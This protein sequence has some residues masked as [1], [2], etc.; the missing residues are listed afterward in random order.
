MNP[1]ID[2][3]SENLSSAEKEFEKALRPADFSVTGQEV[4]ENLKIFLEAC[5]A[6]W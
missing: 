2:P 6:T 3:D 1:N 5:E 4:V